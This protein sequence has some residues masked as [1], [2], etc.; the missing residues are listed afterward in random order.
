MPYDSTVRT[1]PAHAHTSVRRLVLNTTR[2]RCPDLPCA[3]LCAGSLSTTQAAAAWTHPASPAT[4]QRNAPQPAYARGS[5]RGLTFD[6]RAWARFRRPLPPPRHRP[7]T[8]VGSLSTTAAATALQRPA[9]HCRPAPPLCCHIA[10]PHAAPPPAHAPGAARQ[11]RRSLSTPA[12]ALPRCNA[13]RRATAH[14]RSRR[15]C[16][17]PPCIAHARSP[18]PLRPPGDTPRRR[19][20]LVTPRATTAALPHAPVSVRELGFVVRHRCCPAPSRAGSVSTPDGAIAPWRRGFRRPAPCPVPAVHQPR[21]GF[22]A[23]C[24][25]LCRA[26]ALPAAVH[27]A[28]AGFD[29]RRRALASKSARGCTVAGNGACAARRR[30]LCRAAALPAA[31]YQPAP[32]PHPACAPMSV[33]GFGFVARRRAPGFNTRRCWHPARVLMSGPRPG[34]TPCTLPRPMPCTT[35]A[36]FDARGLGFVARRH[37][38]PPR[39]F[40]HPAPPA[41]RAG[42]DAWRPS[43]SAHAPM[44]VRRLVYAA[45]PRRRSKQD[46]RYGPTLI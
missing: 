38:L 34:H 42:L 26:A 36:G 31:V 10:T 41:P 27:H 46:S 8:L 9:P 18:T 23:G 21:A 22:D 32:W 39:G 16:P 35:C 33:R 5:V 2:C 20:Y 30:A 37:A 45:W 17:V 6:E 44:N 12:A 19:Y 25:A 4:P 3:R 13:P 28:R 1:F 7:R 14:A 43:P 11:R 40:R 15:R 29:V 24:R